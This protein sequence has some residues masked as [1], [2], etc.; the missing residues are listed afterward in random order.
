VK[1]PHDIQVLTYFLYSY[2]AEVDVRFNAGD[3]TDG[4][5]RMA[6]D[7]DGADLR[8]VVEREI[9]VSYFKKSELL[10]VSWLTSPKNDLIAD[11]LCLLVLQVQEKPTPQLVSMMEITSQQRQA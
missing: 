2:Y 4:D 5:A 11:S 9:E 10:K 6:G 7:D 8:F 1:Y 3:G